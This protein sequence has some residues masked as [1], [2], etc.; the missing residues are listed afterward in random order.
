M[1][2]VEVVGP[3]LGKHSPIR[4]LTW[5]PTESN[6]PRLE[7]LTTPGAT[8]LASRYRTYQGAR[9]KRKFIFSALAAGTLAVAGL[10]VAQPGATAMPVHTTASTH[11]VR[12]CS[13][14]VKPGHASCFAL[15]VAAANGKVV[16]GARPLAAAFTPTDVQNAYKLTGLNAGGRTVAIVTRS[17]TRASRRP[18]RVPR[19]LRAACLHDGQRLLQADGPERWIDEPAH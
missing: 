7:D 19:Q 1:A 3:S 14:H 18:G 2:D 10:A 17:D 13:V 5:S 6:L 16:S 11:A 4:A 9:V 8:D 15:G 12:A